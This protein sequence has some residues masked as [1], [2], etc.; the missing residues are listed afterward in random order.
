MRRRHVRSVATRR[1]TQVYIGRRWAG[2]AR[3]PLANP[4]RIG[5]DGDRATVVAKYRV[6]LWAQIRGG[7]PAV[8]AELRRLAALGD[9]LEVLCW[10]RADQACHGDVVLGAVAWIARQAAPA[11][12]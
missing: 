8:R 12:D 3:S 5:R 9:T 7:N 6:W 2:E 11:T 4:Y 10:C 1:P